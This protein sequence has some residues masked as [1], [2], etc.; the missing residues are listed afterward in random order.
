MADT[1]DARAEAPADQQKREPRRVAGPPRP[2]VPPKPEEKPKAPPAEEER[3]EEPDGRI[4]PPMRRP[5]S[6]WPA[7][8][9]PDVNAREERGP[10]AEPP[11][12]TKPTMNAL[13]MAGWVALGVVG[14]VAALVALAQLVH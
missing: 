14:T 1:N 12:K 13:E 2:V 3:D 9:D 6:E 8:A 10:K 11:A 7:R 4:P 5:V